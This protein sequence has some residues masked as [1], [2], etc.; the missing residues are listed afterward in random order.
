M[1]SE[2]VEKLSSV[3]NV[4][5]SAVEEQTATT[6]EIA[7]VMNESKRG[8]ERIETAIRMASETKI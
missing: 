6:A 2:S 8:V 3:S 1:Q 5:A 4:I 7:R